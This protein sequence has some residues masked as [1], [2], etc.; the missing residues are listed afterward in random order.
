MRKF[1]LFIVCLVPTLGNACSDFNWQWKMEDWI[2]DSSAIYH[3]IVVSMSLSEKS[4]NDGET[5]P[6]L[7][8]VALRGEEHITFKVFETLKGKPRKI[9]K[10]VLP[11]C[12]GGVTEF[13][14]TGLLFKVGKVWHIKPN[15]GNWASPIAGEII[16]KMS[17]KQ[18]KSS[19]QP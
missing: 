8:V 6:L 4:I 15:V 16:E 5:D 9:L 14:D 12:I 1:I 17:K 2:K 18:H 3:G 13:G 19:V 10:V 7:N 11:E